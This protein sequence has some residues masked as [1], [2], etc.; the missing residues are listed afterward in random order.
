MKKLSYLLVLM[1]MVAVSCTDKNATDKV[2]AA[3]KEIKSQYAPDSRTKTFEVSLENGVLKGVT[4]EQEAITA[5]EQKAAELGLKDSVVLLP[6]PSLGEKTYGITQQSVINIR[7]KPGYSQESGTQTLMGMPM[8]ILESR[9]G[10]IRVVT[11]EGYIAWVT[12]GSV[13]A[14]DE[15]GFGAWKKA[16]KWIVKSYYTILRANP[17]D[18]ADVVSDAVMGCTVAKTGKSEGKYHQVQLPSG[19]MAYILK[20]DVQDFNEWL[21]SRNLTAENVIKTAKQFVG[22]P[23]MWGGTS[24]KGMD[25]SGFVKT[26]YF[27]N[28]IILQRD[29][30]QQAYTGESVD[31]TNG[32]DNL[33][34]G[35]LIFFGTPATA[36]KKERI[37]HVGLYMGEGKFIHCATS[38]RINSLIKG[39][40]D[41]YNGYAA[42][43]IRAVRVIGNQDTGKDIVS[44]A[45][46]P[47]YK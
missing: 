15:R 6:H 30:S 2:D 40:P 10:W 3:I 36:E 35:D 21:A 7:M 32:I 1:A 37:S 39:E 19:K 4:T 17:Y 31:V 47:W 43:V 45:K 27:M 42:G 8:R 9:D 33:I 28:G 34:P 14:V 12:S 24:I 29:A 25:C 18:N 16:D 20:E 13:A 11:P 22:F 5:L 38:V 23:Y 26:A 41:F 46:H 44:I